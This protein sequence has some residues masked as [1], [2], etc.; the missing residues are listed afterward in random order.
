M[1]LDGTVLDKA[2][3]VFYRQLRESEYVPVID[4][5][6]TSQAS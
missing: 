5:M 4:E 6:K 3:V 2:A 1:I